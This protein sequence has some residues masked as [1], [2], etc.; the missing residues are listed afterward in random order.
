M[1]GTETEGRRPDRFA[2]GRNWRSFATL[3][4]DGRIEAA[5]A[6]LAGALGRADLTGC[7]FLDVGC[8]S[9]LFSLAAHR[10]GARVRSFDVDPDSV[11]AAAAL[12]D[13]FAPGS[14]WP[15]E[16]GS[17][18]DERFTGRL[19][20]YDVVYAWGVLHHT[21]DLWGAIDAASRLVASGG[22]LYLSVYN[23]QGRQSR[24]WWRVK[25]RYT[26]SGP[27]MRG[28]LLAAGAA[29]L[30]RRL[31][32]RM[33]GRAVRLDAPSRAV[34]TRARGMSARHDLVDWIGGFPFEVARPEEVFDFLRS[35]G[36]ALRHL[37]T[38]GGGLGCN[39]FVFERHRGG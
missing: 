16:E 27:L 25:R 3:V 6:S 33:L 9:G 29:Y 22:L 7:A 19:G 18:L 11:V 37:R 17:I 39:E 23:D 8:G 10:L 26:R 14:D 2:F 1:P 30:A 36:F 34:R 24:V 21:G 20:T 38:C 12:R 35:R 32:L 15:I 28:V 4:D 13:R 5:G 31:P